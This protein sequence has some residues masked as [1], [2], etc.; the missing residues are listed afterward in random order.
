MV[1]YAAAY[2]TVEA[3]LADLDAVEQLHKD[4][5]IGRYDAAVIGKED[6]KPHVVKRMDRPHIRVI[7]EWF[8]GGTLPRKE[9]HEAAEQLTANQAGLIA[10]GEPTIEK[11]LDKA[12]T[13]ADRVVKRTVE[14]TTGE[15]TSEL[16]EALKS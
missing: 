12:L 10:V 2:G 15:L 5:M 4:E 13:R 1:V 11:G 9:L 3:A 8:G 16:Q 7:P 6:G 14:A